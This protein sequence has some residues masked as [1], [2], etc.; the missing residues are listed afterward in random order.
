[1]HVEIRRGWDGVRAIDL[2]S[3]NG[4]RVDGVAIREAELRDGML[5]EIGNLALRFGDL[6]ER[7]LRATATPAPPV[8]A[9]PPARA[10]NP[11]V[12]YA[13]VAI[14]IAALAGMLWIVA[15]S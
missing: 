2:D 6:A 13:A 12:F 11:I 7:H 4:T 1:M 3:K 14:A 15:A 10:R 8:L 9:T 5:L